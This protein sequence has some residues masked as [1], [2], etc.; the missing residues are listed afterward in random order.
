MDRTLSQAA[1]FFSS[2]V[3]IFGIVELRCGGHGTHSSLPSNS[4]S[5]IEFR[6]RIGR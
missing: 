2:A 5:G 1:S 6:D 3:P 4:G